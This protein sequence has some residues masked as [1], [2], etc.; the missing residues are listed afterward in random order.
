MQ[1]AVPE[2]NESPHRPK[3]ASPH[4]LTPPKA[5]QEE[6]SMSAQQRIRLTSFS[7]GAG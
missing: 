2:R 7:H 6:L 5:S 1:A 3:P 4:T